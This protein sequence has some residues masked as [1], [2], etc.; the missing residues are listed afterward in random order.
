MLFSGTGVAENRFFFFQL[1]SALTA[2]WCLHV[3]NFL[4]TFLTDEV[5]ERLNRLVTDRTSSR[6]YQIQ[7]H[8][9]EELE[10]IFFHSYFFLL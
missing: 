6:I 2:A 4:R 8:P 10:R 3:F 1:F 5:S 9:T 7:K